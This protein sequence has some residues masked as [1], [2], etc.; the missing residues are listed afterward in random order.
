MLVRVSRCTFFWWQ[1]AVPHLRNEPHFL[2]ERVPER[3]QLWQC[4]LCAARLQLLSQAPRHGQC[5][6]GRCFNQC[7]EE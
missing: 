2:V 6:L 5:P 7:A 3:G 4:M 1:R